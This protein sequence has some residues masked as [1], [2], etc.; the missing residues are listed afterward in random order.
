MEQGLFQLLLLAGFVSLAPSVE[1][2]YYLI[3]QKTAWLDAQTYCRAKYT[4]LATVDGN[5]DMTKLQKEAEDHHFSSTAW[6]GLYDDIN[7][8]HWSYENMALQGWTNWD[9]NQPDNHCGLEEC[10]VMSSKG[11]WSDERCIGMKP[12]VCYDAKYIDTN[13]FIFI[14]NNL[15]WPNAQSYCRKQHTDLAYALKDSDNNDIKEK[16]SGSNPSWIGLFRASWKWSDHTRPSKIMWAPGRPNN[17]K[18]NEDCATTKNGLVDDVQCSEKYDFFCYSIIT[19]KEQI[20]RLEVQSVKDVNDPAVKAALMEKIQEKL[21]EQGM[22]NKTTL[23]W[24][25]QPDGTVFTRNKR[26]IK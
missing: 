24:R 20:T 17:A 19:G 6:I 15:T 22:A 14:S 11:L 1:R 16:I 2:K 8:W 4:D 3:Q 26:A 5:D 10:G 18:G 9:K 13:R 23:K 21:K 12:F 25:E 7:S